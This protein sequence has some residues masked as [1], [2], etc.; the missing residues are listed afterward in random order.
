MHGEYLYRD[1]SGGRIF[2]GGYLGVEFFFMVTGYYLLVDTSPNLQYYAKRFRKLY[3]HF[4]VS[5]L[6]LAAVQEIGY[7]LPRLVV[8]CIGGQVIFIK[9]YINGVLWFVVAEIP[10]ILI[11]RTLVEQEVRGA[12]YSKSLFRKIYFLTLGSILILIF[13]AIFFSSFDL[14]GA[15]VMGS[16]FNELTFLP[17]YTRAFCYVC[18]GVFLRKICTL[19]HVT[20]KLKRLKEATRKQLI[21]LLL[22]L[23]IGLQFAYPH[24]RWEFFIVTLYAIV[25]MLS[26]TITWDF[27]LSVLVSQIARYSYPVYAYQLVAIAQVD[28]FGINYGY[29]VFLVLLMAVLIGVGADRLLTVLFC[30]NKSY[31]R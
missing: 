19:S 21:I 24:S 18:I 29:T 12:E 17:I 15:R 14:F 3:P 7:D 13:V 8:N 6:L 16:R 2:E 4:F 20:N 26:Q 28:K 1:T 5:I 9:Q 10:A 22:V 30:N 31:S 25:I 11:F 23:G 27:R